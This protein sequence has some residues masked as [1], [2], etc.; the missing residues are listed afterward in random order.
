MVTLAMPV[1]AIAAIALSLFLNLLFTFSDL[2]GVGIAHQWSM[3]LGGLSIAP[4]AYGLAIWGAIYL[5][6]LAAIA[7]QFGLGQGQRVSHHRWREPLFRRVDQLLIGAVLGQA[8][9]A[10]LF[11]A[12]LWLLAAVALVAV[13]PAIGFVGRRILAGAR[14]SSPALVGPVTA[15]LTVISS[16]LLVAWATGR[17]AAIV[18][19]T[20]FVI[21]DSILG[22]RKFVAEKRRNLGL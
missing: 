17:P 10:G 7:Y 19:A 21:S 14:A 12:Q 2:V 22:W 16:M 11:A 13:G 9:W 18:G 3:G 6:L 8:L 20:L 15:Y 1:V 4:A 5:G